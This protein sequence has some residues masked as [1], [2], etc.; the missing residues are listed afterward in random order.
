MPD[1]LERPS[2]CHPHRKRWLEDQARQRASYLATRRHL[3]PFLVPHRFEGNTRPEDLR[4]AQYGYGV[5]LNHAYLSE[6]LGHVSEAVAT[7]TWGPL[8]EGADPGPGAPAEGTMGRQVW[9]DATGD[10]KPW[11]EFFL[12]PDGVLEWMLSSPGGF[13]VV[14]APAIPTATRADEKA[15]GKRPYVRRVP[16]SA[17][18]D[19]GWGPTGPRWV[20]LTEGRDERKPDGQDNKLSSYHVLYW[21]DGDTSKVARYDQKG[22]RVGP[23]VDLGVFLD[24]QGR[25]SLPLIEARYGVHPDVPFLG[26]GLLLG[27]EDIVIDLYNVQSETREGFR[28]ATFGVWWHRGPGKDDVAAAFQEGDRLIS[29]GDSEHSAIGREAADPAETQTGMELFQVG[30]K[31]WAEAAARQAAEATAG[32]REQ[33]GVALK[34]EFQLDI[35]PL[36]VRVASA[37]DQ[38]ETNVLWVVAQMA[39]ADGAAANKVGATRATDFQVEDEAARISRLVGDYTRSLELPEEAKV[40]LFLRWA[41]ASGL[42]GDLDK[43]A[44]GVEGAAVGQ[45]LRQV[46]E[47]QVRTMVGQEAQLKR[48]QAEFDLTGGGAGGRF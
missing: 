20:K 8:A 5:R 43:P 14:D 6:L 15:A 19:I 45:T 42:F 48:R 13:V 21:L 9:D 35:R 16:W 41:E 28:D 32:A 24:L 25:P 37:L 3:S 31:A 47:A 44:E 10:G 11:G 40:R 33:S 18:E 26:S 27:L 23:E 22:N 2:R 34:A 17:V 12:G 39:G 46:L 29:L 38:V 7:W 1:K 4:R 30:I 36:L